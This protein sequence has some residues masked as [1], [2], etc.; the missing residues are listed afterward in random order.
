GDYGTRKYLNG[1][2]IDA[3]GLYD[4][5]NHNAKIKCTVDPFG[6]LGQ[7]PPPAPILLPSATIPISATWTLPNST[8]IVGQGSR[9][10]VSGVSGADST[11][12][13][14]DASLSG[15]M[16]EM[17]S[18]CPTEGCTSVAVEH[19]ELDATQSPMAKG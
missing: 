7:P 11:M 10:A 17:G 19:L 1:A 12:L 8:R 9:T 13:S 18:S 2:V 3:R 14:A 15:Y 16:I 6:S 4:S 5:G